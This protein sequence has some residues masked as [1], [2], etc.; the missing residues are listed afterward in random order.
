MI[1]DIENYIPNIRTYFSETLDE[2]DYYGIVDSINNNT[3]TSQQIETLQRMIE[4]YKNVNLI[5]NNDSDIQSNIFDIINKIKSININPVYNQ[6]KNDISREIK[7][8]LAYIIALIVIGCG[9]LGVYYKIN[10]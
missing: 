9:F 3:P 10:Y 5:D 8:Q 6:R 4:Q 1:E 7:V 2:I